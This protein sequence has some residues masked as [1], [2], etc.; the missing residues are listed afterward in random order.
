MLRPWRRQTARPETAAATA[1]PSAAAAAA[2]TT[3]EG[4]LR[5]RLLCHAMHMQPQ[6]MPPSV[7]N[8]DMP[9]VHALPSLCC[10]AAAVTCMAQTRR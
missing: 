1:T 8:Q 3:T 10:T 7:P 5:V 9:I 4:L 6:C 2:I